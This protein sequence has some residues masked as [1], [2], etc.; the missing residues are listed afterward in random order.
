MPFGNDTKEKRK[1]GERVIHDKLVFQDQDA[2]GEVTKDLLRKLLTK[3]PEKRPTIQE[4]KQHA[5]FSGM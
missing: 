2:V 5:Y 3:N 1:I 4:V